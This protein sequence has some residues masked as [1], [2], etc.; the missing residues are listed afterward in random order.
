MPGCR[1][2]QRLYLLIKKN[3]KIL[4]YNWKTQKFVDVQLKRT[5]NFV[6]INW[7]EITEKLKICIVHMTHDI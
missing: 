3:S 6:D 1:F 4:A 2:S 5:Q 7:K